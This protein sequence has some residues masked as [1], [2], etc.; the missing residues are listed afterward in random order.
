[1]DDIPQDNELT[2]VETLTTPLTP[3]FTVNSYLAPA[4]IPFTTG[5]APSANFSVICY[6]VKNNTFFVP[7]DYLSVTGYGATCHLQITRSKS[8][9]PG[10]RIALRVLVSTSLNGYGVGTSPTSFPWSIFSGQSGSSLVIGN[11]YF[12]YR[13]KA[14]VLGHASSDVNVKIG[15]IVSTGNSLLPNEHTFA[16][17]LALNDAYSFDYDINLSLYRF[18]MTARLPSQFLC[19]QL[20][21]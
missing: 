3:A 13:Q 2:N 8:I 18:S 4:Y 12:R 21:P 6:I 16:F 9:T 1:M 11:S 5:C 10:S 14:L 19:L 20:L 7:P 15:P 17:G